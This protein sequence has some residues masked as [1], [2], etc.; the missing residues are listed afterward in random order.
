MSRRTAADR[1]KRTADRQVRQDAIRVLITRTHRV[2][3]TAAESELLSTSYDAEAAEAAE[4]RRTV[5]GQQAAAQRAAKRLAAA[6][7]A[8]VENEI[9][10]RDQEQRA[11]EAERRLTAYE[12]VFGPDA[13]DNFHKMQHRAKQ[14]E[15]VAAETK[16]LLERRTTTLR[17]RAERAEEELR[18][19][20][21]AETFRD[22]AADTFEGR[23]AALRQ[24]TGEGVLTGFET[25][26]KRAT[27][28]EHRANEADVIARE[29]Q[30]AITRVRHVAHRMRAGSPQGAAAIYAERIEQ[31]LDNDLRALDPDTE[32]RARILDRANS[33]EALLGEQQREHDI[34][35]AMERKRTEHAAVTAGEFGA[36]AG[37]QRRR[38]DRYRLAWLAARRDRKADRAA[39]AAELPLVLAGRA[40]LA[41]P[42]ADEAAHRIQQWAAAGLSVT[43]FVT[44]SEQPR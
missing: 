34:A 30:D 18:G 10:V 17:E 37:K 36:E 32:I 20:K 38:A 6:E 19:Y 14:A 25:L 26:A 12:S 27:Q 40:A 44:T 13:V 4:L 42:T 41:G 22:A 9:A 28:A 5:A 15:A 29:A 33:P 11:S 23:L 1:Q 21:A 35:L 39:M 24:Q 3:L 16:K 43:D 7:A 31:A 2:A 8:I